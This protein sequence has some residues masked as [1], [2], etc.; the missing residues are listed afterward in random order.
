[1]TRLLLS[2]YYGMDNTGDDALLA[3]TRWGAVTYL[4]PEKM[5]VTAK[6]IPRFEGSDTLTPIYTRTTRFRGEN[7]LRGYLMPALA[8]QVIFGGGSVFHTTDIL[9]AQLRTVKLAGGSGHAAVGVS[10]GPFTDS[11]AERACK[12]LLER[13]CFVGLRDQESLDIA[14]AICPSVRS[15]KTFDLAPL[16]PRAAGLSMERL[17][18]GKRRGIGFALCNVDQHVGGDAGRDAARTAKIREVLRVLCARGAE[19][20]EEIVFIDFNGN[21]AFGD[22]ELHEELA[23]AARQWAPVR[24]VN[25]TSDPAEVLELVSRLR[26]IVAMRLHAAVFGYLTST[27]TVM[28]SYHPKCIGWAEQIGLPRELTFDSNDFEPAALAAMIATAAG[29]RMPLAALPPA[30]AERSALKNWEWADV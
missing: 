21:P 17:A 20:V 16:L 12:A 26:A 6:S 13:L 7:R 15:E 11:N 4:K 29:G 9:K 24:H 3:V 18:R 14:R 5:Y 10:I 27:P 25:Y 23:A 1:M 19:D 28:L 2:G 8:N 30:A 22:R